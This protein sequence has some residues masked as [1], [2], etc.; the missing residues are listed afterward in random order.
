V[1]LGWVWIDRQGVRLRPALSDTMDTTVL[2][3]L[4][5]WRARHRDPSVMGVVLFG[6]SRVDCLNGVTVGGALAARLRANG[7]PADLAEVAHPGL[8]P[9][10]FYYLLDEVLAG[11]PAAAVVE[12]NPAYLW[13]RPPPPLRWARFFNLS[14]ELSL[15][16]AWRMRKPLAVDGLSL[17]DPFIYALEEKL[18]LLYVADGLRD[19][20][21][22]LLGRPNGRFAGVLDWKRSAQDRLVIRGALAEGALFRRRVTGDVAA[23]PV[24]IVLRQLYRE[25]RQAG[26]EVLFYVPPQKVFERPDPGE[27]AQSERVEA[28]RAAIGA[29]PLEWL[30]LHAHLTPEAF[31]G[32]SQ[33][34]RPPGCEHV[35]DAIGDVLIPRLR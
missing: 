25:L 22:V 30:D 28:V 1:V 8:R 12:V 7:R 3:A 24:T 29:Q 31:R 23:H 35:A 21:Q 2:P 14:R 34:L 6:D 19:G 4:V 27:M 11:A 18:D 17:L 20:G 10:Q 33:Y 9:L 32:F 13:P 5:R 26:V 16:G 15:R